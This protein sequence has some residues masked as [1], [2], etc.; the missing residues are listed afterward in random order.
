VRA[1]IVMVFLG[2][3]GC[4]GTEA[5][6]RQQAATDLQCAQVQIRVAQQP[7]HVRSGVA[8]GCDLEVGYISTWWGPWKMDF[9]GHL[10]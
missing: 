1:A 5:A 10:K 3:G 2:L 7:D 9:R 4:A 8:S 6:L